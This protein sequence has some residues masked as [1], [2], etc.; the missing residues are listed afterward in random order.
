MPRLLAP[1]HGQRAL[2]CCF[3]CPCT[4]ADELCRRC[5]LCVMRGM[6]GEDDD[7]ILA[8]AQVSSRVFYPSPLFCGV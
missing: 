5:L 3:T 6:L 2:V 8:E 1:T 4:Q 7:A